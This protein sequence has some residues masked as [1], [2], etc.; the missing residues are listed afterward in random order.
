LKIDDFIRLARILVIELTQVS[1]SS[2][3]Q[4][5]FQ[6]DERLEDSQ[7]VEE[8]RSIPSPTDS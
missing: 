6:V 2:A 4:L 3:V 1:L 7:F 8:T 5:V